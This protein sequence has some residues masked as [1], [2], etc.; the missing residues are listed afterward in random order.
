MPH[1]GRQ[2]L[3][4]MRYNTQMMFGSRPWMRNT[5]DYDRPYPLI[6]FNDSIS[7][8]SW[9]QLMRNHVGRSPPTPS[10][11]CDRRAYKRVRFPRPR[12][13]VELAATLDTHRSSAKALASNATLPDRLYKPFLDHEALPP[14]VSSG[15][16]SHNPGRTGY[17]QNRRQVHESQISQH[18][19]LQQQ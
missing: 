18:V 15:N 7:A 8:L 6:G 12:I 10:S 17:S 19:G 5:R 13:N 2:A 1:S 3:P 4:S 16:A 14:R 11:R 9:H